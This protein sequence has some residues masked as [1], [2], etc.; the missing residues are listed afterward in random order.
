MSA[1]PEPY[2]ADARRS[3]PMTKRQKLV[4]LSLFTA[5][6]LALALCYHHIQSG[7]FGRDFP[8]DTFLS[9]EK[10][11]SRDFT[12]NYMGWA[13]RF[14]NTH[15][16]Y[17]G[18]HAAISIAKGTPLLTMSFSLLPSMAAGYAAWLLVFIGLWLLL[19]RKASGGEGTVY[20][21]AFSMLSYPFLFALDR[22]NVEL[23][24]ALCT[25][26]FM[27]DYAKGRFSRA[28]LWLAAAITIKPFPIPFLALFWADRKPKLAATTLGWALVFTTGIVLLLKAVHGFGLSHMFNPLV[29]IAWSSQYNKAYAAQDLGLYHGHSLFG[30][31]KLFVYHF[32]N[33]LLYPLGDIERVSSLMMKPYFIIA[34]GL[35][36]AMAWFM[37]RHALA[38]WQKMALCVCAMN[39]L[40]F[41]SADYKML[42]FFG[43]IFL[44]IN[45]PPSTSDRRYAILFGLLLIPKEYFVQVFARVP[46]GVSTSVWLTPLLMCALVFLIARDSGRQN[47]GSGQD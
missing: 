16:P 9:A 3:T 29:G 26:M 24:C 14:Y 40:P 20:L 21:A 8:Y 32:H 25:I 27:L 6:G 18:K 42:H 22:A 10:E 30:L 28:S 34:S 2:P 17:L 12:E 13:T 7:V 33:W 45:T 39:L 4:F 47:Q 46:P 38:T 23:Y 35:F 31:M 11:W 1:G 44:F 5:C 36:C 37:R 19:C 15:S 41:V 43:P